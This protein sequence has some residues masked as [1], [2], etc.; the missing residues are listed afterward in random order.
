MRHV[1]VTRI[2]H[3]ANFVQYPSAHPIF[4]LSS[5]VIS[6]NIQLRF[7]RIIMILNS[8]TTFLCQFLSNTD[9][10]QSHFLQTLTLTY[11]FRH[12]MQLALFMR[13]TSRLW[14]WHFCGRSRKF[15]ALRITFLGGGGGCRYIEELCHN[16][17]VTTLKGF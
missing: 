1:L 8:F 5:L 9:R 11:L 14:I 10:Y 16:T 13:L 17:Q 3:E 6:F 4:P 15:I 7:R 12:A 2:A